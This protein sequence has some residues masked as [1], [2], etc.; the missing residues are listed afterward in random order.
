MHHGKDRDL[1]ELGGAAGQATIRRNLV[2]N[3]PH[4]V[5]PRQ[6]ETGM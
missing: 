1:T 3:L 2:F 6:S 4:E 5:A